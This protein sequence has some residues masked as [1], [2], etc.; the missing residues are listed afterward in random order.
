V[1]DGNYGHLLVVKEDDIPDKTE[2]AF[3]D[4]K[5]AGSSK[6]LHRIREHSSGVSE[7]R[8]KTFGEFSRIQPSSHSYSH[9]SH[10]ESSDCS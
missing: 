4:T 6:L 10:T 7:Q 2:D 3:I 9:P 8:I 5:G 1:Q